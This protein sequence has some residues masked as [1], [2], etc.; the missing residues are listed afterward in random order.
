MQWYKYSFNNTS[1]SSFQPGILYV[2]DKHGNP[3]F[4][5]SQQMEDTQPPN[6]FC[7]SYTGSL[8]V[9]QTYNMSQEVLNKLSNEQRQ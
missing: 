7:K 3:W 4:Q 2:P 1:H 6:M 9:L 8:Y 5:R